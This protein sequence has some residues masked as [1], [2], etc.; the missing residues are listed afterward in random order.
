[1]SAGERR[2]HEI[3]DA[4]HQCFISKGYQA[5]TIDDIL[6]ATGIAKGT[7]YYH[8]PGKEDIMHAI[9][10]RVVQTIVT[11]ARAVADSPVPPQEKIE[12]FILSARVQ[13][14]DASLIGQFHTPGNAEFHVLS[15]TATVRALAPILAEIITEGNESGSFATAFPQETAELI[16]TSAFMLTDQG[17]FPTDDTRF[18]QRLQA[19]RLGIW[20]LLG[21]TPPHE[22]T[23][24]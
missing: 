13:G 11:R 17:F 24:S 5:T 19:I 23:R 12:P 16:L 18:E 10:D 21:S 14:E 1:M 7:L 3:M 8:F 2:R 6:T 20:K 22:P 4:A 15:I 9:I